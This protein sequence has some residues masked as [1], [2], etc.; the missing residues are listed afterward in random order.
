MSKDYVDYILHSGIS[1]MKWGIR[2]GPRYPLGDSQT[3]V[4]KIRSKIANL[5][6]KGEPVPKST[7]DKLNSI[8]GDTPAEKK[9]VNK[10]KNEA[11]QE[12]NKTNSL[13][14]ASDVY[15]NRTEM[16]DKEI[17]NY[18]KRV[19]LERQLSEL[20]KKE[21]ADN[22]KVETFIKKQAKSLL[23]DAVVAGVTGFAAKKIK[24]Y[25]EDYISYLL[26]NL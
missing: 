10:I 21:Y 19:Q 4:G 14:K 20:A 25:T 22:H 1:G 8:K 16:S 17:Q 5:K 6:E 2:N 26:E 9:I 24:Q 23:V 3:A 7:T 15:N 18:I 12:A 11:K 13:A